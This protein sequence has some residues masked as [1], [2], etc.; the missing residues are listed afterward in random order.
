M[1]RPAP[2]TRRPRSSESGCGGI[3]ELNE[4]RCVGVDE[5]FERPIGA[6]KVLFEKSVTQR[7]FDAPSRLLTR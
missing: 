4:N 1:Q 2:E 6:T 3:V 7:P 5:H